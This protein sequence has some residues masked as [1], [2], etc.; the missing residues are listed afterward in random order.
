VAAALLIAFVATLPFMH[1]QLSSL[2]WFILVVDTFLFLNDLITAALLYA[3]FSVARVWGLLTLASGYLF[4]ALIIVPHALT[5]P[6]LFSPTGLIGAGLQTT[7]WLNVFWH[8][9]VAFSAIGYAI[10]KDK[11]LGE[12]SARRSAHVPIVASIATI[13]F[14]ASAITW[15]VTAGAGLLPPIMFDAMNANFLW[16]RIAAPFILAVFF[17]AMLLV[18]RRR[19]SVLDLW[20]LVVL[21]A[22]FIETILLSMTSTRFSLIWYVGRVYGVLSSSFVL[23]VLLAESTVLYARLATSVAAQ[24]RERENRRTSIEVIIASIAHELQQPLAAIIANSAAEAHILVHTPPDWNELRAAVEDI[25]RDGHRAIEII[26]SIREVFSSKTQNRTL[27]DMNHLVND[28]LSVLRVELKTH[29]ISVTIAAADAAPVRGHKGQLL[30]VLLNVI[31]NAIDAMAGITDRVLLLRIEFKVHDSLVSLTIEDSGTGIDLSRAE[32]IF[33]PFY[34]TKS[35]G[36][37][38]GLAICRSIIESH[39]GRLSLSPAGRFG[40]ILLIELPVADARAPLLFETNQAD[41]VADR[42]PNLPS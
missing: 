32:Q 24:D 26:E 4:N 2:D 21:W 41:S 5:F 31:T 9:G 15:I 3:Q 29:G 36:M 40:S 27:L 35:K 28:A 14:L 22:W 16:Q 7:V 12:M 20:L 17:V 19:S 18:W 39:G 1:R 25:S 34:T 42:Q 33:E 37:G 10:L 8:V 23:L 11:R 6:G 38:L 13:G 30:Q